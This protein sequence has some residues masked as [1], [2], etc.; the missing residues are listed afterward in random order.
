MFRPKQYREGEVKEWNVLH[1]YWEESQ[2]NKCSLPTKYLRV[3]V[4][5]LRDFSDR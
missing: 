3:S 1:C 5:S 4:L 2:S